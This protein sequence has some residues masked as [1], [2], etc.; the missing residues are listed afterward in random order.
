MDLF[1]TIRAGASGASDYQI[2]RSLRFS[3]ADETRLNFTPSSDGNRKKWT[4]AAWI[5]RGS[6]DR[7]YFWS[8]YTS[9]P[10]VTSLQFHDTGNLN[11]EDWLSG[12]RFHLRT[13]AGFMR[14]QSAWFH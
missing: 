2:S 4:W 1:D 9:G 8:A 10:N 14:D 13:A 3:G 7:R 11:F 5:K 6:I 12:Y